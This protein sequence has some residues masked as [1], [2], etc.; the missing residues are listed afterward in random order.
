MQGSASGAL[1]A[2][3]AS[4]AAL[5]GA[6]TADASTSYEGVAIAAA[7]ASRFLHQHHDSRP[8]LLQHRSQ[9]P[10]PNSDQPS[11]SLHLS[12][13][14]SSIP[15]NSSALLSPSSSFTPS[16]ASARRPSSLIHPPAS[17]SI[18][19]SIHAHH[20]SRTLQTAAAASPPGTDP[21]LDSLAALAAGLLDEGSAGREGLTPAA[22]VTAL[23]RHIV[24]QAAAKRA[25][26]IALRNRWRRQRVQPA[27]FRDEIMP[28]NILMVG[29][30]G[31]GKTEVARRLAKLADAPFIKVEAT[32]YT[33]LGYVGR[34]VEEIIKDLVEAS[35]VLVRQRL[36]ARLSAHSAARA[37]AL[38]LRELVG[39]HAS[40]DTLD[41][42]R[43]M[44]RRGELDNNLV[45]I[46]AALLDG[47]SGGG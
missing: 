12:N 4:T 35:L 20:G 1:R 37:E 15:S 17:S 40:E 7:A 39:P 9:H 2:L 41:T 25:V 3:V 24:G 44:Y 6:A 28:K 19:P 30:T 16:P 36:K 14:A 31:C 33:E 10:R 5:R 34:D 32:K 46:D 27:A 26:A 43:H 47:G 38:I 45:D 29:P 18:A 11:A 42:F 8:K 23:D 22:I 21:S 13:A